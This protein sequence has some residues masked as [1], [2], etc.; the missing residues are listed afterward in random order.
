[1]V[2]FDRHKFMDGWKKIFVRAAG[3]GAGVVVALT[4]VCGIGF[5][6]IERPKPWSDKAISA[7]FNEM[8]FQE[9]GE[10][11]NFTFQYTFYNDTVKEYALPATG[12]GAMMRQIPEKG[13]FDKIENASWDN[14]LIIP[15]KQSLNVKFVVP[16]EFEDYNTSAKELYQSGWTPVGTTKGTEV[17]KELQAFVS[18]RLKE[19][20]GFAFF[21][22]GRKYKIVLPKW[23]VTNK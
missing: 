1:M 2:M 20:D 7:K 22:Y 9:V 13:G 17:P 23:P 5:W 4:M 11:L 3:V 12:S 15:P 16:Y 19:I 18:R 21:D 10:Q 6:W 8:D 14:N